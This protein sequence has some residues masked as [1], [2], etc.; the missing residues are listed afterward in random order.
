MQVSKKVAAAVVALAT[1]FSG[2]Y[3]LPDVVTSMFPSILDYYQRV[4]AAADNASRPVVHED[5]K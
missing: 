1:V 3:L 2:H 5:E 4:K